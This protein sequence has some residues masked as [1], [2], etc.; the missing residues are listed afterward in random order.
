MSGSN[1]SAKR[2]GYAGS[3]CSDAAVLAMGVLMQQRPAKTSS[4]VKVVI[5]D[6]SL[7]IRRWL[8]AVIDRDDRLEV[9][10]MAASAQEAREVIKSQEPDVIT[11]DLEMPHMNGLEF[12]RHLMR[13]RP[14]PVVVFSSLIGQD[15]KVS[16]AARRIGAIAT[17]SKPNSPSEHDLAVL[18]DT[19]AAAGPGGHHKPRQVAPPTT[20]DDHIVLIGASTGGVAA[21]E[22]VLPQFSRTAPPIVIAQ[23]MPQRF[24][25]SF[26]ERLDRL[27]ALNVVLAEPGAKLTA[28]TVHIAPAGATQTGVKWRHTSW[29]IVS[30]EPQEDDMFC[31][32]V[33]RLFHSAVPWAPR[34][35]ALMLTGLGSDGADGMLALFKAGARTVGQSKET[36]VV[37]GMP[38]AAQQLGAVEHEVDVD[39]VGT[40]LLKLMEC[41]T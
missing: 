41:Q 26:A 11:L 40:L 22:A 15:P 16:E 21:I 2:D 39:A 3:S 33:N 31:P 36:C 4:T 1:L 8:H 5:V 13:L 32:S 18:C 23:H 12:L 34:V 30:G 38:A 27:C 24:L 6:D 9:V 14:M 20:H 19:L 17:I 29:E 25:E 35:G 7:S 37:Y 10:G 28:G